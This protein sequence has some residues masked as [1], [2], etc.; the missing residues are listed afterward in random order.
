MG[1]LHL[2]EPKETPEE[3]NKYTDKHISPDMLVCD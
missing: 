2:K 1:V 3:G